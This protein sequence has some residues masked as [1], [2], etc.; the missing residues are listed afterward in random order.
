MK[1]IL[2][3]CLFLFFIAF[4][5]RAQDE[6]TAVAQ[7]RFE[8]PNSIYAT[9]GVSL[10]F[11]DNV[12]DYSK[13][14]NF[15][16]GYLKRLN[17]VLSIGSSISYIKFKYDPETTSAE[18]GAYYGAGDIPLTY[19][20]AFGMTW[21]EKYGLSESYDYAYV[22]TLEGGDVTLLSLGFN[23][24]LNF[25]PVGDN[26]KFSVYGF[27]KPFITSAKRN[28]VNGNGERYVYEA[29]EDLNGTFSDELDDLLYYDQGDDT[30]YA[31]GYEEDW[32]PDSY[33]ALKEDTRITG[34]IFIGP[35][36]EFTPSKSVSLFAQ[37]AFGYTFPVSFV[38]TGSYDD[39]ID[40]YVDPEFPIIEKGFPSLNIQFGFA[41]NF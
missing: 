41:F 33:D 22:L 20:S 29:Y 36:I 34:G 5:L 23:I 37:V 4:D 9:G 16:V 13:G 31:D 2:L 19:T 3:S 14:I 25:V 11:G 27:A 12:G 21:N 10:T 18:G 40:S 35:G 30:W 6:G 8:N 26:T 28:A 17:K 39:S 1:K 38:S 24:K 7:T 15:E 32:G